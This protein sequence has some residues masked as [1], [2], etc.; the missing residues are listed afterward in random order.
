MVVWDWWRSVDTGFVFAVL[1]LYRACSHAILRAVWSGGCSDTASQHTLRLLAD[2]ACGSYQHFND[3]AKSKWKAKVI[4]SNSSAF[5][6]Y[7]I[8]SDHSCQTYAL[9][10]SVA[11]HHI[12]VHRFIVVLCVVVSPRKAG[13]Q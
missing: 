7:V 5:A 4:T 13:L 6:F 1:C 3:S 10:Q 9:L 2:S 12:L 8:L 11:A